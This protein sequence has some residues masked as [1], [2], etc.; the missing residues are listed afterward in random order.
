LILSSDFVVELRRSC[1]SCGSAYGR[2]N[3]NHQ[4][5]GRTVQIGDEVYERVCRRCYIKM[6]SLGGKK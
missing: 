1:E 4:P 5:T 6:D 2:F 3:F